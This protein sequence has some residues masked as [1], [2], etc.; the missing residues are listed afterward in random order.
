MPTWE[1]VQEYARGKYPLEEDQADWFSLVFGYA[2]GRSQKIR[3]R[4]FQALA[5]DWIEFS[6]PVCNEADLAPKAALKK[7]AEFAVGALSLH[8][9]KYWMMYKA[10]LPT[11]DM[12]EFELPLHVL[13]STADELEKAHA[14]GKDDF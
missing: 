8:D 7:N 10:A 5:I 11:L 2:D 4:R 6:S 9:G 13:A 3:V 12:E 14:A 1:E